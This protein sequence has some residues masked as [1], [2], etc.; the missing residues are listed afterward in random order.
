M[1]ANLGENA[2][3]TVQIAL[4]AYAVPVV[5]VPPPTLPKSRPATPCVSTAMLFKVPAVVNVKLSVD[6]LLVAP[7]FTDPNPP[8][9]GGGD[10]TAFTVRRSDVEELKVPEVPVILM[11]AVPTAAVLLAVSV[12]TLVPEVGLGLNEAMTPVGR[13]DAVRLTFPP[14]PPASVMEMVVVPEEP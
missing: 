14:K 6:A 7:M 5:Q 4:T 10:K 9:G 13:P 1:P 8:M 12:S 2:T 11:V 3:L